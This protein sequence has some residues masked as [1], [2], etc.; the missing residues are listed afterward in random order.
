[1]SATKVDNEITGR[2]A[3][4]TGASGGIGAACARDLALHGVRLALTY[5]TNQSAV[6]TLQ[7]EL[8]SRFAGLETSTHQCDIAQEGDLKRLFEEVKAKHGH[9]PDILFANA[10]YGKR[11]PHIL[12]LT[13]AE[14]DYT[15]TC[16]LRSAFILTQLA[17][18]H[19]LAQTWGRIIYNSSIAA[20]GTSINGCHYSASKAGIQGLSK[21]LAA[22][23]GRS[24]VTF[25]DIAPAMITGT[26]M[27]PSEEDLMGTPGDPRGIPVGRSG[28]PEECANVVTMVCRTG[29][30]TGQ[31]LLISGGLK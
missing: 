7:E 3:L 30:M 29:Y 4:I 2:L 20:G 1:M 27:I 12:D 9:H 15:L 16:N 25:N 19:M 26:G 8:Q 28:R 18:P 6:Q 21:N 17:L 11:I 22:K 13:L 5:S 24:G 14:W 23:M 31:S 10:G